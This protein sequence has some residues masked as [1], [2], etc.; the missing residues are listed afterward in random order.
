[1][2]KKLWKVTLEDGFSDNCLYAEGKGIPEVL[3]IL[4]KSAP[5]REIMK[6]ELISGKEVLR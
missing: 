6:I 2:S 5:G 3:E 4:K 1:M